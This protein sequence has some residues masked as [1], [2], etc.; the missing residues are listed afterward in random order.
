M[1][2]SKSS[3]LVISTVNACRAGISKPIAIPLSAAIT[4]MK[5]AF[6]NPKCVP[7]ARTKAHNICAACVPIRMGSLG[8]TVRSR[9]APKRKNHHRRRT[10]R[11]NGAKQKFR[12]GISYTNQLIAVCCNQARPVMSSGMRAVSV[13]ATKRHFNRMRFTRSA[14]CVARERRLPACNRRQ[15]PTELS[16][17]LAAETRRQAACALQS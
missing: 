12:A 11:R 15:L 16:F 13:L 14:N 3:R 5:L 10:D 9:A 2:L 7:A 1:A 8:V 6:A 4:I 17:W